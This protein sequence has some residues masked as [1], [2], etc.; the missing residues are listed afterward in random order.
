MGPHERMQRR[1]V[2]EMV[3]VPHS[4]R[5]RNAPVPQAAEEE[6]GGDSVCAS[7][8]N[9]GVHRGRHHRSSYSQVMGELTEIV[10]LIPQPQEQ[11]Q[12]RTVEQV[13]TCQFHRFTDRR[14]D[15]LGARLGVHQ[16]AREEIEVAKFTPEV[17]STD[18][19]VG[20]PVATQR[21]FPTIQRAQK[22]IEVTKAQIIDNVVDISVDQARIQECT[23]EEITEAPVPRG[24]E[25]LKPRRS[26][27]GS[28][29]G[30]KHGR[31][32]SEDP[33]IRTSS[34]DASMVLS[35]WRS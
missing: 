7:S 14:G 2:E 3:D 19:F 32:K 30:E 16:Q 33:F 8:K 24:M 28:H 25:G 22:T 13:A 20:M 10:K 9:P 11:V 23:V 12:Y 31:G 5:T 18:E 26:P 4:A 21:Q 27:H 34:V 6:G 17:L 15:S 1:T 35:S 29:G